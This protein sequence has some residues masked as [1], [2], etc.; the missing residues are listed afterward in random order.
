MQASMM[1]RYGIIRT[2]DCEDDAN[3]E[4]VVIEVVSHSRVAATAW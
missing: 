3:G 4:R 2:S 1:R